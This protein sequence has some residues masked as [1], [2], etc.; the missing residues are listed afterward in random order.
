MGPRCKG[1][2][3][4][5][6][7]KCGKLIRQR[8]TT[9]TLMVAKLRLVDLESRAPAGRECGGGGGWQMTVQNALKTC[10]TRQHGDRSLKPQTKAGREECISKLLRTLPKL[11]ELG[12]RQV[13]KRRVALGEGKQS[14]TG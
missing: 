1:S 4:A 6:I 3:F 7:P 2:N 9:T 11:E 12:V 10:R 13:Y 8:L 14:P 5:G